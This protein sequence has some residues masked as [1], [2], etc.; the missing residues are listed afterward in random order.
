MKN[1]KLKSIFSISFD[2]STIPTMKK[3]LIDHI[4]KSLTNVGLNILHEASPYNVW[5]LVLIYMI[6]FTVEISICMTS[7][8]NYDNF[9]AFVTPAPYVAA[10]TVSLG[11]VHIV[12]NYRK[13]I[14]KML[15]HLDTNLYTYQD[16]DTMDIQDHKWYLR[17]DNIFLLITIIRYG[18]Y[19]FLL[20]VC[21]P[22]MAEVIFYHRIKTFIYPCWTPWHLDNL[23]IELF[24]F[25][26]QFVQ[27]AGGL[28]FNHVMIV[29][30]LI[31]VVEFVKQYERLIAAVVSLKLRTSMIISQRKTNRRIDRYDRVMRENI[32]HCIR[33]HQE[34]Y[35]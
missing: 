35:K 33:H 24:T 26:L 25:I 23:R 3:I 7:I 6:Y 16:E 29:L 27:A 32:I 30:I 8:T 2:H 18:Q 14:R 15:Y 1:F 9:N 12:Y 5:R 31:V 19:V 21:V 20:L 34:L 11:C 13:L 17:N 22:I 28:W 10:I 4:S